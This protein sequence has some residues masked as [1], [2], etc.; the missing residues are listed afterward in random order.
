[1][2]FFF[3]LSS[4]VLSKIQNTKK[5]KQAFIKAPVFRN[6]EV[7]SNILQRNQIQ[8][9]SRILSQKEFTHHDKDDDDDDSDD[10][11]DDNDKD[12]S[13][14]ERFLKFAKTTTGIVT[15]SVG[16][17]AF[18]DCNLLQKMWVVRLLQLL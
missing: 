14:F 11:D 9:Q 16:S 13:D 7:N 17:L 5:P 1:M 10:D 15:L 8:S 3:C 12:M 2:F 4:W 18:I 6:N